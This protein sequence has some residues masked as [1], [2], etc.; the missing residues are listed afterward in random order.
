MA[1][2]VEGK[3][4]EELYS[5]EVFTERYLKNLE[6]FQKGSAKYYSIGMAKCLLLDRL[7]ANWKQNYDFSKSLTDCLYKQIE[8]QGSNVSADWRIK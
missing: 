5:K 3:A 2:Y 8:E 6:S 7:D 1:R 4:Y